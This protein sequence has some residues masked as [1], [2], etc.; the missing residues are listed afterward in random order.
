MESGFRGTALRHG[1][2]RVYLPRIPG[3]LL[4]YDRR[5]EVVMAMTGTVLVGF[6]IGHILGTLQIFMG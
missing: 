6:V 3:D 4:E 2:T 5:Q 1:H